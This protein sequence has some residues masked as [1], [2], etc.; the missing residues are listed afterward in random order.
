M[1]LAPNGDLLVTAARAVRLGPRNLQTFAI[2]GSKPG[3]TEP[4]EK[5]AAAAVTPSGSVLVSDEK[6][7]KVFRFDGKLQYQAPFPDAKERQISRIVLDGEGGIVMLDRDEKTVRVLDETGR[8]LRT[9]AAHGPGYDL[10]KPVDVAV[11]GFRNTY[12][13]DE[14]SGVLVFSPQGQLLATLGGADVRTARAVTIDPSGGVLV[15]DDK[16]QRI[17]RFK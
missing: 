17:L 6:K 14:E 13:A 16:L 15:Y 10:R 3:E 1:S 9:I 11:D 5:L 12:V 2:P 7:K 4:L 8:V